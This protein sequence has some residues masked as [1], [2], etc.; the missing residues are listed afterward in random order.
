MLNFLLPE[1]GSIQMPGSTLEFWSWLTTTPG[2]SKLWGRY[3]WVV[4]TYLQL[5]ARGIACRLVSEIPDEGIVISHRDCFDTH[6]L[7]KRER[8]IVAYRKDNR[9]IR[10]NRAPLSLSSNA[11]TA[12]IAMGGGHLP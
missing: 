6:L 3:H 7:P 12:T 5:S 1:C 11:S 10:R 8:F 2:L 9:P 4:Q